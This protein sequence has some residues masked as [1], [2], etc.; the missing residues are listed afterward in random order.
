LDSDFV[1]K[2]GR[3]VRRDAI[4][5][6][7]TSDGRRRAVGVRRLLLPDWRDD[8]QGAELARNPRCSLSVANE[9]FHLVVDRDAALLDDPA[10][11]VDL[12]GRWAAGGWPVS[13]DATGSA[14]TAEYSAPSAGP[15]PWR[16]YRLTPR[17]ATVVLTT[18]PGV[19][20]RW[21]F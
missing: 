19:G 5:D 13:V 6:Q 11:V 14:L 20:T 7:P 17:Q 1:S 10:V 2:I 8:P 16:A 3:F 12:A 21:R 18:A 15:P 9:E 4:E